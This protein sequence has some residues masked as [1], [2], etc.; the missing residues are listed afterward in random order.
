MARRDLGIERE[1]E[2]GQMPPLPPLPQVLADMNGS[3]A[4]GAR[5]SKLCIH[6]PRPNTLTSAPP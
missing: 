3:G 6:E 1:I 5:R 2:L 4:V